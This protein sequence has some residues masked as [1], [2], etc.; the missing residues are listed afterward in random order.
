MSGMKA[1]LFQKRFPSGESRV[2][3]GFP[4]T[5]DLEKYPRLFIEGVPNDLSLDD[6]RDVLRDTAPRLLR[7][8]INWESHD[9][10]YEDQWPNEMKTWWQSR[11][12]ATEDWKTLDGLKRITIRLPIRL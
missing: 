5:L 6:L 9:V 2:T 4:T 11:Q 12:L 8:E 7:T 10:L 3:S 1:C